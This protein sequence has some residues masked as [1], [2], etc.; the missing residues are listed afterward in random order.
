VRL[1][2]YIR[3]KI[4]ILGM[5]VVHRVSELLDEKYR[6]MLTD[7]LDRGGDF[8]CILFNQPVRC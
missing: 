6:S 8:G 1:Y 3:G 4:V 7:A 2:R 5:G